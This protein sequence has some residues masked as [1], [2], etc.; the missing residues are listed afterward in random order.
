MEDPAA[1]FL[2]T[3]IEGSTRLWEQEPER[4]RPAM[5]RHDALAREAVARHGGEVVKM[6][7]DGLHAVFRDGLAAILAALD[8]QRG[9]AALERESGLALRVRCGMHAGP[10]ERRDGDYF[11]GAVNRA[12]RIMA[13]AHGG[14]V[15]VSHAVA[16]RLAERLAAPMALRDLGLA[17][18]RDLA[19]PERLY[20]LVHPELRAEFPALRSLEGTPNNLPHALSSFV[21][22][23]REMAEVRDLLSRSRLVTLTGM[24]GLGKTRLAL[25]VAAEASGDFPDGVWLAE[26]AP[27][28]D[29]T[30]VAQALASVLGV[31]EEAGRGLLEALERHVRSRSLLVVLDSCEHLL[32]ACALLAHRLLAA[33]PGLR[34]LASS[35]E[36]LRVAGEATYAVPALEVPP[37][38]RTDDAP[39]LESYPAVRLFLER[40]GAARADFAAADEADARAIADICRRLDGIP[41][42]LELAAARVRL[43]SVQA[44]AARLDDRFRLLAGGERSALPRHQALR[45]TIDWSH[46]LLDAE[47]RTLLRRLAVFSGGWML[48][49]A[50]A[51]G[52]GAPLAEGAVLDVLGRLVEKS[53][54][55]HDAHAERY[56]LLETVRE[57][58]L[59][60][61]QAAGEA[62]ATRDAHLRHFVRYAEHAGAELFGAEQAAWLARL[63]AERENLLAAHAWGSR[64]GGDAV[65]TFAMLSAIKFYW[66]NRGLLQLGLG[67]YAALLARPEALAQATLRRRALYEAGQLRFYSGEYREARACLEES[68]AI[69]RGL[70]DGEAIARV[71]QPLGMSQLGEGDLDAAR[72]SLREALALAEAGGDTRNLAAAR[73]ALAQLHRAEGRP[74]LAA[75]LYRS[76]LEAAARL[77]DRESEAIARLNLAMVSID[78]GAMAE[79]RAMALEALR[80]A[81]ALASRSLMQSILEVCAGLAA[82]TGQARGAARLFGAAEGHA[83]ATGLRRDPAD[84]AFLMPLVAKARA[85]LG[86]GAFA[87][88]ALEGRRLSHAEAAREAAAWLAAAPRAAAPRDAAQGEPS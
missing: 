42:A 85:A 87:S 9:L 41:L 44:I 51:V 83:Q 73:N 50:E 7:G 35:R 47:E 20:Q 65:S 17:R 29:G 59:E 1:T 40:A 84:D 8:L 38:V 74:Q 16:E 86:E 80:I 18:L 24:G 43:L 72:A 88:A 39:A 58:A 61:L 48:E 57:Y 32:G 21:G 6:T 15:L 36:P 34:I 68:L 53:L 60:R 70:G 33:S 62:P 10:F 45:A 26:L 14:Q 55:E 25:H 12:A 3:D 63:D 54:V 49:A 37:A 81:E 79:A 67:L 52:A 31:K 46:E 30:R 4:M 56:R 77:G 75:P 19:R 5:A 64:E 69:A 13:A 11:G 2:F 76:V 27:L 28:A 66:L 71:L 78:A 23:E 82:A 22:R